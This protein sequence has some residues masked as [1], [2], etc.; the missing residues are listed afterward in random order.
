MVLPFGIAAIILI[1]LVR[2]HPYK[3][4][5][6]SYTIPPA[7]TPITEILEKEIAIKPDTIFSGRVANIMPGMDWIKQCAYFLAVN[8]VTGND[9]QSSGLWLKHI[10]TLHEYSQGITLVFT[11]FI[12]DFYSLPLILCI[13]AGV[14][15]AK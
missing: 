15:S 6:T 10:P 3:D 12:A 2:H 7:S 11:G 4:R 13:A 1:V 14:I 9:H 8:G 5:G